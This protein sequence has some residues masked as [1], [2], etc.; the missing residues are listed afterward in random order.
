MKSCS[1]SEPEDCLRKMVDRMQ[2]EN[3][4]ADARSDARRSKKVETLVLC[5]GCQRQIWVEIEQLGPGETEVTVLSGTCP[6]LE[7]VE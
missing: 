1:R 2:A 7:V 3:A 4:E 5:P 6:H